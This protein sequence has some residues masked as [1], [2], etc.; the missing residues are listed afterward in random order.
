MADDREQAIREAFRQQAG[1]CHQLGS[2]FTALLCEILAARLDRSTAT[3]RAILAWQGSADPLFDVV[4]L[5]LTG[6]LHA[7]VRRGQLADLAA[8]YPPAPLPEAEAMWPVLA[9]ALRDKDRE[10]LGWLDSPPQTNEAARSAPLMAG[11]LV[12]A[13][14]TG[15]PCALYEVGT[16]AGL[17]LVMD[18]Y[19]YDL[20]GLGV[21]DPASPLRL[22]PEWRGPPPPAARLQVVRRRGADLNP[23]DVTRAEDRERLLAYVWPD[24]PQ[25]LE[26]MA[27]AI[28]LAAADPPAIDRA[29]AGDWVRGQLDPEPEV[30]CVRVLFHSIAFQ[31]FPASSKAAIVEHL[32]RVGARATAKAPLA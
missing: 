30:G 12:I 21:G 18:R 29:D 13:S 25:R 7:M 2:R 24:Q 9:A 1:W 4:P 5:R 22:Q 23:L 20:G 10:L 27:A 28:A 17:N 3:G 6:A 31:Y 16:S 32:A 14:R 8:F 11:M 15:L 26:R 19:A